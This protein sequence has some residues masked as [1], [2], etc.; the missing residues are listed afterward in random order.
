MSSMWPYFVYPFAYPLWMLLRLSYLLAL[1]GAPAFIFK[2]RVIGLYLHW[3]VKVL[4]DYH[5][6]LFFALFYS[7]LGHM[8]PMVG[9]DFRD[10]VIQDWEERVFGC[11]MSQ[12]LHRLLPSHILGEYFCTCYLGYYLF[13]FLLFACVGFGRAGSILHICTGTMIFCFVVDFYVFTYFPVE[14]PYWQLIRVDPSEIGYSIC[15]IV[16]SILNSGSSHGTAFPSSHVGVSVALWALAMRYHRKLAFFYVFVIP[17]LCMATV[18]GGFHY[19]VDALCGVVFGL[20]WS[21]V[22]H[23]LSRVLLRYTC[24][25]VIPSIDLR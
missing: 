24:V 23:F 16:H 2:D 9:A 14:G 11:Q 22:G 18:Y 1:L 10:Y 7:E 13:I 8:I 12:E 15:M 19:G 21:S 3:T 20:L 4:M 6:L 25:G 5:C 17:G